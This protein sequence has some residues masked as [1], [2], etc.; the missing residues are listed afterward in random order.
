MQSKEEIIEKKTEEITIACI[1]FVLSDVKKQVPE[2]FK[3]IRDECDE[4]VVGSPFLIFYFDTKVEGGQDVEAGYQVTEAFETEKVSSHIYPATIVHSYTHRGPYEELRDNA[5]Q[6]FVS[7]YERG[8]RSSLFMREIFHVWD[9]NSPE[10]NV[11]EVQVIPHNWIG[12]FTEGLDKAGIA[13]RTK[14]EILEGHENINYFTELDDRVVWTRS[15]LLKLTQLTS[16]EQAVEAIS[17]CGQKFPDENIAILKAILNEHGLEFL[18]SRM[19]EDPLHMAAPKRV[20]NT[21]YFTKT[22]ANKK[23]YDE[24][25]TLE[26]KRPQ[27]C[28][29]ALAKQSM[30]RDLDLPSIFCYTSARWFKRLWENLLERPVKVEMISSALSGNVNCT[31]AVHLP[32]DG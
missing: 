1:R 24:A 7:L 17:N 8:V 6:I 25:K 2:M 27:A 12:L 26:E 3:I 30:L 28:W 32:I 10:N 5:R 31:F 18:I 14:L 9:E 23:A 4:K 21:L 22:P 15:T 16:N 11:I 20:G 29:V 19:I 13:E